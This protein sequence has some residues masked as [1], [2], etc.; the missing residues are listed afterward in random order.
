MLRCD[1]NGNNHTPAKNIV[2]RLA[3]FSILLGNLWQSKAI[4]SPDLHPLM[5]PL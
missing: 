3:K 5:I 1:S 2:G 4:K